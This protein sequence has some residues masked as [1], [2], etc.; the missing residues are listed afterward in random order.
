M[1]R[2]DNEGLR[3]WRELQ[4]RA[5]ALGIT[6]RHKRADL[7]VL[8]AEAERDGKPR[9]G[10]VPKAKAKVAGKKVDTASTTT[11]VPTEDGG[12]KTTTVVTTNAARYGQ[13][14]RAI[15]MGGF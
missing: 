5:R 8:I 9:R 4:A 12:T 1:A 14:A 7:L 3:E 10:D 11:I 15:M 13:V 2:T 6:G